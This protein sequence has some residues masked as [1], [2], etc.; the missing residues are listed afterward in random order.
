M[1]TNNEWPLNYGYCDQCGHVIKAWLK[2]PKKITEEQRQRARE[3]EAIDQA[4]RAEY[5]RRRLVEFTSHELWQELS[6]RMTAEHIDWWENNGVPYGIQ[7]YLQI[8]Y[9]ANRAYYEGK[10]EPQNIR[11]SPAYTIPWFGQGFEFL[12]MQYRLINP[13]NPKDRYRFADGLGGGT[14]FYRADP[15]QEIGD[16][17][18]ICE[19]AKK[20]IVGWHWLSPSDEFTWLAASSANT[21]GAA[22]EATKDCG[23]RYVIFDPDADVWARRAVATNPK[24]THA[25]RLTAKLDDAYLK[26][27]LDRATFE[28]ILR[29]NL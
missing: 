18:I 10:P 20:A 3:A 28:G 24:T 27:G 26:Y 12:S 4:E 6:E 7:K 14:L 11:H 15:A 13:A 8:G 25:I 23:L 29:T 2:F 1:F 17:V 22:L 19:G 16:K 21:F 5:R 9:E